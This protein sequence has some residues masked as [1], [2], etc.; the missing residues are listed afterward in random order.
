MNQ[1]LP[2][3]VNPNTGEPFLR[4]PPPRGNII[5]TPPRL[6]D[7]DAVVA[8]LNDP[9]IYRWMTG[10]PLPYQ[11]EHGLA[12]LSEQ[13][14]EAEKILRYLE[15]PLNPGEPFPR[16]ATGCPVRIIREVNEDGTD[17]YLGYL[18]IY[19]SERK[20]I[21]DAA[22]RAG[23]LIKDAQKGAGDPSIVWDMADY[24]IPERQGQ[25]IM[26][27]AM[28]ALIQNWAIPRL[29]AQKIQASV[30]EGNIASIKVL[31][32][33][34]FKLRGKICNYEEIQGVLKGTQWLEWA[35]E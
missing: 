15:A 19:P 30:L 9:K 16:L 6:H 18:G 20:E 32:K 17:T 35:R 34:G 28:S 8:A 11:P 10:P 3:E 27:A 24:V 2:L 25:G 1:L 4:L 33:A 5:I 7:V 23:V 14:E 12:W 21:L 31:E 26:T 13:M 22:T 29:N